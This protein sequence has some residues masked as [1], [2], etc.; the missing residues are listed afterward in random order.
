MRAAREALDV[1]AP[2]EVLVIV[3]QP[4][5][6]TK[7]AKIG[8]PWASSR[9][10]AQAARTLR[11]RVGPRQGGDG[12]RLPRPRPGDRPARRPQDAHDPL[13][14]RGGR[15]VPPALP[16]RG[17]GRRHAQP[18]GHRHRVRR[19]ASTTRPA[20]RSSPWSTSRGGSLREF[21]RSGHGFAYSEV[22]R[23]GAALAGALDYAHS[24][25]VV[26]RDIKPANILFTPQGVGEDHGLRRRA[27]RVVQPHRHRAVHRHPELHVA[28]AGGRRRRGRPQRPVLARRRAVRAAD[29]AA[30]VP[31][32]A[33][34]PRS[35]TRSSTSRRASP[36]QVRP[37]LPSAFNPIVLK[38]L[39][40]DPDRRY[41]RG[42]RR[43][44]ALSRRCGACS[45]G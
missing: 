14:R 45:P 22:A 42:R 12:C 43:R 39:E 8:G 28:R 40:K 37:G 44:P 25:G 24:K 41:A 5:R 26:H 38:L 6:P 33:P 32:A 18:P 19:R 2:G 7:G 9:P 17:A 3:P 35:R 10:G 13:G 11:D 16:A 21:L 27:P 1:A 15:G 4:P 31:G 23:I 36:S 30:P 20:C 29:R 34:S